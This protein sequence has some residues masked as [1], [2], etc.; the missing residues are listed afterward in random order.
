ML[1]SSQCF[2]SFSTKQCVHPSNTVLSFNNYPHTK[3]QTDVV[4]KMSQF[5]S[6]FF[7]FEVRLIQILNPIHPFLHN[8]VWYR[9]I[10]T[11]CVHFSCLPLIFYVACLLSGSPIGPTHSKVISWS[12]KFSNGL[13]G[14]THHD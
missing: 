2:F 9:V 14:P 5:S 1:A 4:Q 10:S 3:Q 8:P 7:K 6:L 11:H 13:E 12:L